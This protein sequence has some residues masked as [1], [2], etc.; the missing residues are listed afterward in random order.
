M[1]ISQQRQLLKWSSTTNYMLHLL[2]YGPIYKYD[3][4]LTDFLSDSDS[5]FSFLCLCFQL[6]FFSIFNLKLLN[7]CAIVGLDTI[8]QINLQFSAL[9]IRPCLRLRSPPTV[10][11]HSSSET[12]TVI[13]TGM[14][15][16]WYPGYREAFAE[17][18]EY[19][20]IWPF[21]YCRKLEIGTFRDVFNTLSV[22]RL[23]YH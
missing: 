15:I 6:F 10:Q 23:Y 21:F 4:P 14:E 16:V 1:K 3:D 8:R 13:I 22:G 18:F 20:V 12:A 5:D 2:M 17:N 9:W 19:P 7:F 11:C